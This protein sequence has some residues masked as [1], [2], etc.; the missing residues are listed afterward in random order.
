[1]AA[2]LPTPIAVPVPPVTADVLHRAM[3]SM[4]FALRHHRSSEGKQGRYDKKQNLAHF[5]PLQVERCC[6]QK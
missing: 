4:L 2:F 1:M 3:F 5:I 6:S